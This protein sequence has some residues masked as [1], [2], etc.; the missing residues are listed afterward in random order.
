MIDG[1]KTIH[2]Q[3]VG[4]EDASL[5]VNQDVATD[6]MK[7]T[8]AKEAT[9]KRSSESSTSS[10][11]D[12]LEALDTKWSERFSRLE[13]ML[14]AQTFQQISV[15]VSPEKHSRVDILTGDGPFIPPPGSGSQTSSQQGAGASEM[16]VAQTTGPVSKFTA[17][18]APASTSH[19]PITSVAVDVHHHSLTDSEVSEQET[20]ILEQDSDQQISEEQYYRET[21]RGVRSFM[22]WHQLPEFESSASSQDDN[23]FANPKRQSTGKISVNLPSDDWLCRKLER[24]NLTLTEGYPTRYTD[25]NGL[26]KDQFV[27]VP[28]TQR[29]YGMHSEKKDFSQ[30]NVNYWHNESA[31]LNSAFTRIAR[32]ALATKSP[33]SRPIAQETLRKWE[34]SARDSTFI[35]NQAAGFSR[36]LTKVQDS[37]ATQLKVIQD[38]KA[39]GKSATKTCKAADELA[40]LIAFNQSVTHAMAR[41]MQDLSDFV[42]IN[43]ANVTLLRRDSYLDFLKPGVKVDT[44]AALRNSPLH[45]AS[46]FPDN[47][48]SKAE[49]EIA[50]HEDKHYTGGSHKKSDRYHPYNPSVK[51][52]PKAGKK[53]GPPAWKTLSSHGQYRRGQGKASNYSQ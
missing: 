2:L 10:S 30:S 14:L 45:M 8:T 33:A 16:P 36:C 11:T 9:R 52:T 28:H 24:L 7:G 46:L 34:K 29:W 15:S 43:M 1:F 18:Q 42:F 22:G 32:P 17:S 20:G 49:E 5:S 50:H 44:V 19:K 41:T 13:A 12:Y 31:K 4:E 51:Q 53:S 35:C 6:M 26:S 39:K 25:K 37:M 48:I 27:K 38:E 47:V 23:P 21:V 40:Y 3:I